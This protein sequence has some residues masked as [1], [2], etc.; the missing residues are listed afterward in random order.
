MERRSGHSSGKKISLLLTVSVLSIGFCQNSTAQFP[1]DNPPPILKGGF[2]AKKMMA[3]RW[4]SYLPPNETRDYL[5][6]IPGGPGVSRWNGI[7]NKV[8]L[9][10]VKKGSAEITVR[11]T[12]GTEEGVFASSTPSCTNLD[13]FGNKKRES[14]TISCGDNKNWDSVEIVGYTVEMKRY[15]HDTINHRRLVY[16]HEFGHALSLDHE[17]N[18]PSVMG[19]HIEKIRVWEI[20]SIDRKHL[21]GKWGK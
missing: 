13:W 15:F 9:S 7:T 20:Q 17:F 2:S 18:E 6:G 1:W 21:I 3:L 14:G 19:P 5:V 11:S 16:L 10:Q 4:I 12:L 8:K